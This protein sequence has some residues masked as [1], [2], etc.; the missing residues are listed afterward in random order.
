VLQ[1]TKKKNL[2]NK[3]K[4]TLVPASTFTIEGWFELVEA[5]FDLVPEER[6][7]IR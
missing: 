6:K 4:L 1:N 7:Y 2:V 3:S 5:T